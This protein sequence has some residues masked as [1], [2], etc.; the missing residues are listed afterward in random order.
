MNYLEAPFK[1]RYQIKLGLIGVFGYG[2]V[3]AGY[4]LSGK[5]VVETENTSEDIG[6]QD[7]VDRVDYGYNLG[8]GVEFLLEIQCW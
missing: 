2:G 1:L 8:V 3:Y 5:T 4:A 7:F 6:F